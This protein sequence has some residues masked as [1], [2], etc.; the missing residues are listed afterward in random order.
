MFTTHNTERK[1]RK[2]DGRMR[3][4]VHCAFV[5]EHFFVSFRMPLEYWKKITSGYCKFKN[6]FKFYLLERYTLFWCHD[7]SLCWP[8]TSSYFHLTFYYYANTL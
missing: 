2:R 3:A 7:L 6:K 4:R 5:S 1:R 8:D